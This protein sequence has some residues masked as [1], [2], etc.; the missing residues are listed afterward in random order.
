MIC[1]FFVTLSLR[2]SY[3]RLVFVV[4]LLWLLSRKSQGLARHYSSFLRLFS[5]FCVLFTGCRCHFHSLLCLTIVC[6]PAK[7]GLISRASTRFDFSTFELATEIFF[8]LWFRCTFVLHHISF[9][10]TRTF[11]TLSHRLLIFSRFVR[12]QLS[13]LFFFFYSQSAALVVYLRLLLCSVEPFNVRFRSLSTQ[14]T[15]PLPPSSLVFFI[16]PSSLASAPPQSEFVAPSL[17][18]RPL[19]PTKS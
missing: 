2:F 4:R 14:F 6:L 3:V 7:R 8:V 11:I 5:A 15:L 18:S 13:Q 9:I 12:A 10:S 17:S 1:F 16:T 19:F